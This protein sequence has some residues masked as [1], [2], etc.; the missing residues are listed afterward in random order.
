MSLCCNTA[1]FG[2]G[3]GLYIILT[4]IAGP[5]GTCV[6]STGPVYSNIV[7]VLGKLFPHRYNGK[8]SRE[9]CWKFTQ[10]SCTRTCNAVTS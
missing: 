7:T 2:G 6:D 1:F 5:S 3:G 4:V 8:T 9:L 10:L